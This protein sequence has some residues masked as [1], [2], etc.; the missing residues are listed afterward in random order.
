MPLKVEKQGRESSQGTARRF[1][2]K[3]RRSGILLEAR[4]RRFKKRKVSPQLKKRSALRRVRKKAEFI[5]LKKIG[6][7]NPNSKYKYRR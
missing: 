5:T 2:Q 7:P 3:I 4:K 1:T 6:K